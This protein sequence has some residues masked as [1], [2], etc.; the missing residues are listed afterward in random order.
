MQKI[1]IGNRYIGDAYVGVNA[2]YPNIAEAPPSPY[3]P[4]SIAYFDATGITNESLKVAVNDFILDMKDN[5]LWDKFEDG[6]IFPFV[7]D[8][9]VTADIIDQFKINLVNPTGFTSSFFNPQFGTFS[10]AGFKSNRD[11]NGVPINESS[12]SWM[13]TNFN[14]QAA[15]GDDSYT[16]MS[17]YTNELWDQ[18]IGIDMGAYGG[19]AGWYFL[20]YR[21]TQI[22]SLI[23]NTGFENTFPDSVVKRGFLLGTYNPSTDP[24]VTTYSNNE[25]VYEYNSNGDFPTD[26]I[27]LGRYNPASIPN[28]DPN[29]TIAKTYQFASFGVGMNSTEVGIFNELVNN[30]QYNI[31][32]IFSTNR[33]ILPVDYLIVAGGGGGG[34]TNF[35]EDLQYSGGGGAGGLLSGSLYLD[36]TTSSYSVVVGA[37]GTGGGNNDTS[38]GKG[39]NST[40]FGLTAQGGGGGGNAYGP[41][42][43]G[44]SG[45]GASYSENV[46]GLGTAG[47]GFNGGGRGN[48]GGFERGGCGGGAGGAATDT[49]G[50]TNAGPGV[51]WLDGGYYSFGGR[52]FNGL[53]GAA[54]GVNTGNGGK[55]IYSVDE[56][57]TAAR[58]GS[59][60]VK[61]RYK[62]TP[63]ATGGTITQ[64]G[65]YTYH[66]FTSNGTFTL[67]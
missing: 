14:V 31:D 59:G 27:F 10:Y 2:F 29:Q 5:S 33:L 36:G 16:H 37:G 9:T 19:P 62:G 13:S 38:A 25:V 57:T 56:P 21:N 67:L 55:A 65:G 51:F 3:D 11:P 28:G 60:V 54:G 47:Q 44:G 32:V 6:F 64:S 30:F 15:Y 12:A 46:F 1:Y 23:G 24:K 40:A 8:K 52:G 17:F 53:S 26:A 20:G 34:Q 61:I 22:Y 50:D 66:T 35:L 49:G 4:D 43:N 7:T 39:G 63:K 48:V 41:G 18:N 45:G 58:G 42:A